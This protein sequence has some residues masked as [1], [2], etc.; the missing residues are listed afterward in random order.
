MVRQLV[1]ERFRQLPAPLFAS[2]G[3]VG[4]AKGA[5]VDLNIAPELVHVVRAH[6]EQAVLVRFPRG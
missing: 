5:I 1:L 2:L 3:A 4:G 6:Y